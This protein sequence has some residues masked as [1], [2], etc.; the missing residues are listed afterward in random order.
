[1][2]SLKQ[3]KGTFVNNILDKSKILYIED[4]KIVREKTK[5]IFE[6]FF[7]KVYVC[8]DGEDGLALFHEKRE[9][10]DI[11]LT[12]I[13]MPNM[14]G[15]ELISKIREEDKDLPIL[16]VTAFNDINLLIRLIKL[17]ISDYILKPMQIYSTLKILDKI[18]LDRF[19]QKLVYKQKN[20][21]QIYKDILDKENLLSETNPE[22]IITYVNDI[23]CEVSGYS[24]EE[25]IGSNHN[26]I[27][28][29]DLSPKIYE[30]LWGT[31]RAKKVW[32]GKIKNRAKDGSSF[33]VKSTIFPILD[34]NGNIQKY[35]ASRYL[36]TKDEK[37]RHKLKKY[38]VQQK[39]QQI[40]NEKKLQEKFDDDLNIAKMQNNQQVSTFVRELNDQV[41]SLR[42][43]NADNKG[44]ILFLENKLKD[45]VEKNENK[46][47]IYQEKVEKLH[48]TAVRA[49][50]EYQRIKKRDDIITEKL[51]KSQEA[52][53][54][55]QKYIDEYRKKI[56]NLEDVIASY[57]KDKINKNN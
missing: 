12:D 38:I 43:K 16:I 51:E 56:D 40:K 3:N 17:N 52:I 21:L 20:E 35:V 45:S 15:V 57:E 25:L 47:K 34:E 36:I 9:D 53:K 32:K 30:S 33:Y 44:R 19:N 8:K 46:V 22:G 7:Q 55:L 41:K 49:A 13:N 5:S 23:F 27:R 48:S 28:D 31:I 11:L 39:S 14:D 4:D 54:T 24:K 29:P 6:K 18:L 1:M 42:V 2:D 10:I 50:E 26:I 37:E